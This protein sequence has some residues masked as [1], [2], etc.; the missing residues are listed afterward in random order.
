VPPAADFPA[1][2][3]LDQATRTLAVLRGEDEQPDDEV[4]IRW[5]AVSVRAAK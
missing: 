5:S 3:S 1:P 4:T 2:L